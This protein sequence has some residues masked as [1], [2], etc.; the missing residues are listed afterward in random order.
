[1]TP[2]EDECVAHAR[3]RPPCASARGTGASRGSAADLL[4][5]GREP[6]AHC[7]RS[8]LKKQVGAGRRRA[9]FAMNLGVEAELFVFK[10]ESLDGPTATS[11]R[12][13]GA[14]SS[15]PT[16]AYDVEVGHGR[17]G[18]P[19][20]DG[21][22]PARR[23]A[24]ACSA[25]T[26]R[27]ATASTSS[28]STYAAALEMA[29]RMTFFRLMVKQVAKQAGLIATFMPKPYTDAW[30]SGHH[31]NMSL[32]DIDTGCQPVP[33][34]RRRPGQG[35]EQARLRLRGRDHQPRP[36]HRRGGHADGQLLQ[37]PRR[38]A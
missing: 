17:H 8:I 16:Q 21:P 34:R 11:S 18:L 29:D 7:T 30:G 23:R 32:E 15:S 4:F 12:W 3:P 31:F 14:G 36:G 37:A 24:S 20:P 27:A 19:R 28:T 33:R 26:P 13:P 5:G 10:P 6:F 25:S 35:L 38:P 9:G 2:N 1:M 22:L